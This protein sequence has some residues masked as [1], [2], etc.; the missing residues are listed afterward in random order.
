MAGLGPNDVVWA[1]PPSEGWLGPG[2]A[3][4]EPDLLAK[5]IREA[6]ERGA[7]AATVTSDTPLGR[8]RYEKWCDLVNVQ[9]PGVGEGGGG[10]TGEILVVANPGKNP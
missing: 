10:G 3:R 7:W 9:R 2:G 1:N 5:A 8:A 4:V 6:A